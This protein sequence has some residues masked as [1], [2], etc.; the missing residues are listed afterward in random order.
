MTAPHSFPLQRTDEM[1]RSSRVAPLPRERPVARQGT[2]D[3]AEHALLDQ[4]MPLVQLA[5]WE[6]WDDPLELISLYF[7]RAARATLDLEAAQI[8]PGASWNENVYPPDRERL[9]AFLDGGDSAGAGN[10]VDYRLIVG[11]GELLWVRHWLLSVSPNRAGRRRL[12]GLLMAIPE[13]KHSEWECLRVS[14]RECNRIGQELHDDLCQVLAG[15]S[16]MMRVLGQRAAK[17]DPALG[18]EIDE[19]NTHV[20]GTTDRVRS[21]AHGLFPAQLNYATLRHALEEFVKQT[22][23]RFP[24]EFTLELP[25]KLPQHSPEQIIH[26]YRIAQEAV[27]NAVRHGHAT[28]IK[29][30]IATT[31]EGIQMNVEDNG[32]GFPAAAARPEG[33]GMHVMQYR[34]HVLGGSLHFHNLSPHGAAA[35]LA[36]PVAQ[37][38]PRRTRKN[39]RPS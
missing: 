23:T 27:G 31:P 38:A 16:F 24:V 25:R 39:S 4:I 8:A 33:I 19:L 7:G 9:R 18:A 20:L 13:Q 15:L 30:I 11:E 3:T 36:Y 22:K 6:A 1:D 12:R 21:M 2:A 14:E 29:L 26:V 10:S 28:A 5:V 32:T 37:T 17:V 34:A 35:Q